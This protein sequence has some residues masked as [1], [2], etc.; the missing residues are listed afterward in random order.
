MKGGRSWYT[1]GWIVCSSYLVDVDVVDLIDPDDVGV[2]AEERKEADDSDPQQVPLDRGLR[3]DA[4]ERDSGDARTGC[5][6]GAADG[7]RSSELVKRLEERGFASLAA[8]ISAHPEPWG[9][10]E[11]PSSWVLTSWHTVT[12]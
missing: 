2:A 7:V 4:T 11:A 5:E 10:Q 9:H 1:R 8:G 3:P 6:D 12:S